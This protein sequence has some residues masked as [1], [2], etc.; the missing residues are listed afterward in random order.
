MTATPSLIRDAKNS[1]DSNN[2]DHLN[3]VIGELT[4]LRK[5][6]MDHPIYKSLKTY[7]HLRIFMQH[8]VFAVWDFM[9]LLKFLQVE[10]TCVSLPWLPPEHA[11]G[12]RL[13]NE[14]VLA[15]ESDVLGDG[16][17]TSH[18]ALY[19]EAMSE[20]GANTDPIEALIGA[21]KNRVP[22]RE[23]LSARQ[24]PDSVRTFVNGTFDV[25]DGKKSW[26]VASAFTFGREEI[27]PDMFR[28]F[29]LTHADK[30][31]SCS[32]SILRQY[33]ELHIITDEHEHV[34]LAFTLL[35]FLCGED[36]QKWQ[37][38]IDSAKAAIERRIALWDGVLEA[39]NN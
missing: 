7:D 8:H 5:K 35:R 3:F 9:S 21:L 26:E 19:L 10:L 29:D 17:Y 23:A 32:T 2:S 11:I 1:D 27:I 28:N 25:I 39:L 14:I 37:E 24:I 12:S 18:F 16:Q 4:P 30:G 36:K 6:L 31:E 20:C 13:V 22:I 15:E 34:P 33:L 38:V